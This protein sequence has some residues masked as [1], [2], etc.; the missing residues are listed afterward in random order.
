MIHLGLKLDFRG[1]KR[2]VSGELNVEEE[3]ASAE[4]RILGTKD[5]SCP[6]AR[7]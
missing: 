5:G 1:F 7:S 3:N 6:V 2:V 4:R